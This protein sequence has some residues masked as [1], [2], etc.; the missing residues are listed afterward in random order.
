MSLLAVPAGSTHPRPARV[1]VVDDQADIRQPMAAYLVRQGFQTIEA[2]GAGEMQRALQGPPVDAIVL[3]VMLGDGNGLSLC[4]ELSARRG[5]PVIL[6]TALDTREAR[7][8]GLDAG[9]DDYMVKPFDPDELAARLRSVLR[10]ARRGTLPPAVQAQ[11][12]GFE[13]WW[14]D[15]AARR[16]RTP[17]GLTIGLSEVEWRILEALLRHPGQVLS[18]ERLLDLTQ[19]EPLDVFD[20]SI[21]VQICRLRKK[22]DGVSGP[23]GLIRTVRGS[24]YLFGGR[25][26][27]LG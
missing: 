15:L 27:V 11:H 17:G 7:I 1:L 23:T 22:L 9:A 4:R 6:L 21:D 24:G 20:R 3:D 26:E 19:Q 12:C 14:A 16:L 8:R 10:R 18:R 5:P 13:G 2:A 25:V